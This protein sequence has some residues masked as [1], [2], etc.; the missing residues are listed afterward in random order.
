MSDNWVVQNLQ[1]ALDTWNKYLSEIWQLITQSPEQFKGGSIWSVIVNIHDAVRAIGLALLV[2]FFVIGIVK[3]CGS[4]AE[5]KKPEHALKLFIRFA[6]AKGVVTY[7]LEL[8]MALFNIVQ[9]LVST[10]M[11]AAGFGTAQQTVLP[12]EIIDAVES[13]GFFESIPLW[14]VTLIGGLFIT[15][16]SFIMIMTVYASFEDDMV[17]FHPLRENDQPFAHYGECFTYDSDLFE[18]LEQ[19]YSLACMSPEA[20][21]CAWY[22]IEDLQGGIEHQ[23]GM[24][25]YL[26]Y[27]K[28]HGVTRVQLARLAD[29][30]GMDVMKLY[31]RQAVRGA[32]GK[33]KKEFE[34]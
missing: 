22:E 11:N 2:L 13:C 19:G 3:T 23:A 8:M 34:R 5:V 26:H 33:Q 10:I 30:D 29:Y 17:R 31:D 18:P 25:S 1:N 20:H 32:Q 28:Q 14:A 16:L 24:Q 27:C 6:I 4:F 21:A 15:V 7:G 9:G 12:Q